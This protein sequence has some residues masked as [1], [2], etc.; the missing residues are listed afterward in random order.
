MPNVFSLYFI[1]PL[2][3]LLRHVQCTY[4]YYKLLIF[5]LYAF[6]MSQLRDGVY[7]WR[8]DVVQEERLQR[9]HLLYPDD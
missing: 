9:P 6:C 2:S 5:T 7:N 3:K 8:K 1:N 4:N